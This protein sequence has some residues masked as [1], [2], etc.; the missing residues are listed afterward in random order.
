MKNRHSRKHILFGIAI[1]MQ[2][3][4]LFISC[5]I[6]DP[7]DDD[8]YRVEGVGYIINGETN[9]PFPHGTVFYRVATASKNIFGS[10][11]MYEDKKFEADKNGCFRVKFFKRSDGQKVVSYCE[12]TNL[13]YKGEEL[14]VSMVKNARK[15]IQL[16]TI[17]IFPDTIMIA[18]R[19]Y[20]ANAVQLGKSIDNIY[21]D[22]GIW[23]IEDG[24]N[25]LTLG[26]L[27]YP[28]HYELWAEPLPDSATECR[29]A[30]ITA[31]YPN[32]RKDKYIVI[33]APREMG[34]KPNCY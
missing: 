33:Q 12:P 9:E 5:E 27:S 20:Y 29:R 32:G 6:F 18:E 11:T 31:E 25:W 8:Y 34:Y 30:C 19:N 24:V 13:R 2:A 1:I 15:N 28:Y 26:R 4:L 3:L 22:N 10:G 21:A 16:D 17:K 7:S 14:I 23:K